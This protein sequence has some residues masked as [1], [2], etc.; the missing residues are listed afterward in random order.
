MRIIGV[1][2]A[3]RGSVFGPLIIAGVS[4]DNSIDLKALGV[5]DSKKLTPKKRESIFAQLREINGIELIVKELKPSL[6]DKYVFNGQKHMK[7]N[8]LEA[9]F[10]SLIINSL[11]GELAVVDAADTSERLFASQIHSFLKRDIM[12]ISSHHA[13]D[14]YPVVSAAS[15]VAK[16]NRDKMIRSIQAVYGKIGSGYPSDP[17]TRKYLQENMDSIAKMPFVRMS[18]KTLKRVLEQNQL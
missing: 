1:D 7:L 14:I 4:I 16:V 3:G 8:Y 11:H 12:L 5:K 13:D 2:E 10:M 17:L 18:W 6:I 15:I 9:K